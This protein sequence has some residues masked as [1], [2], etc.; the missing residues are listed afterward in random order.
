MMNENSKAI[1][2]SPNQMHPSFTFAIN[3]GSVDLPKN[4]TKTNWILHKH[5]NKYRNNERMWNLCFYV[6]LFI[7]EHGLCDG[8]YIIW[9]SIMQKG[10]EWAY[11][12]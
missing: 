2:P 10:K 5:L 4:T 3:N 1:Q 9:F 7:I 12:K 11:K 6:Y 8:V